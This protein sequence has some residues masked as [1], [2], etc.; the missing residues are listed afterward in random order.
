MFRKSNLLIRRILDH[1]NTSWSITNL[2]SVPLFLQLVNGPVKTFLSHNPSIFPICL[3]KEILIFLMLERLNTRNQTVVSHVL[4]MCVWWLLTLCCTSSQ[5]LRPSLSIL[6][7]FCSVPFSAKFYFCHSVLPLLS[8]MSLGSRLWAAS[9]HS[10]DLF[11]VY[12]P[13]GGLQWLDNCQISIFTQNCVRH[14][15]TKLTKFFSVIFKYNMF[16]GSIHFVL[17]C[18]KAL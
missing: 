7:S 18:C 3:S 4:D 14:N 16:W 2:D 15:L 1:V 6:Q 13:C 10:F 11:V 12:L 17:I 5:T 9:L 8:F